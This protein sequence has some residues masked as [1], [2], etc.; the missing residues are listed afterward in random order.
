MVLVLKKWNVVYSILVY[1]KIRLFKSCYFN[2]FG[3]LYQIKF[4]K[5][6]LE[7]K[8]A[9]FYFRAAWDSQ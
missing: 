2:L 6:E 7:L 8:F 9:V 1:A 3:I 5:Y 4:A